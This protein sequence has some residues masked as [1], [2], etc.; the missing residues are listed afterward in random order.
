MPLPE[1]YEAIQ[2]F[3]TGLAGEEAQLVGVMSRRW[4]GVQDQ[5]KQNLVKLAEQAAEIK[6]AGGVITEPML[7]KEQRYQSL[8][9]QTRREINKYTGYAETTI[10]GEQLRMG[11]LGQKQAGQALRVWGVRGG[12]D[13]LDV[14]AVEAMVGLT[15][16]G[17][18]VKE[19]LAKAWPDAVE[20]ITKA[21]IKGTALGWNPRKTAE[22]MEEGLDD[23]LERC[24]KIA[25]TEQLRAYRV[26]SLERYRETGFVVGYRR[27][28]AKQE[29]TCIA[30]LL[31]DGEFFPL[32]VEFEDHVNGRCAMVPVIKGHEDD[33][34][35]VTSG[36]EWFEGLDDEAQQRIMGREKW[37]DWKDGE[38][39]LDELVKR[40]ES[41]VWG[42]EIAVKTASEVVLDQPEKVVGYSFFRGSAV[43]VAEARAIGE[44][45]GGWDDAVADFEGSYM[46]PY[47]LSGS[48]EKTLGLWGTP[49][50]SLN[51]FLKGRRKD[52]VAM[53]KA[54]GKSYNQEAVALLLPNEK[55]T[56]GKLVWDFDKRLSDGQLDTIIGCLREVNQ[57]I[58]SGQLSEGGLPSDASLGLTVRES[59]RLELW[60]QDMDQK[61][62]V[63]AVLGGALRESGLGEARSGWQ[64]G[65]DF[66][67]LFRGTDY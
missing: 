39:E 14:G 51:A 45:N 13:Q 9:A 55:G 18:P 60:I 27:L 54:W 6:A 53:A 52:V 59:G 2:R 40:T 17:S 50:P 49:E 29:R 62:I 33:A 15:A 58:E 22:A 12:F 37:Q 47:G 38:F 41:P 28:A 21:L 16:D 66:V 42:T 25:R 3:K 65:S 64:G 43:D 61:E 57:R 63:Q 11:L 31:Q 24:L 4:I 19:L 48:V 1:V 10:E 5:L 32:D 20:G 36:Q 8:L 26:A 23:G 56:G 67:L 7:W 44:A 35:G 34:T 46:S 30:C